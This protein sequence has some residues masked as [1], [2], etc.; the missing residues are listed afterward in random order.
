[1]EILNVKVLRNVIHL[2]RRNLEEREGQ[3]RFRER[4]DG[5]AKRSG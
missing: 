4:G 3:V 2:L 1:M 5:G